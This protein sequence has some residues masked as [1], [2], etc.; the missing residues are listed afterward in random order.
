[1]K[2]AYFSVGYQSRP[3]LDAEINAIREVL[4][5]HHIHLFIF[6]DH[7]RFS[8]QE[9]QKMMQQAFRE[10]ADAD[11]L[12]AEISEKA[13]GVGIEI[14]YAVA[15]Q[16]P[17]ICLRNAGAEHSTTASGSATHSLIYAN[18][19]AIAAVLEPVLKGQ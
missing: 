18:A 1:M 14:G 9:E 13:M 15:L 5:K 6:V 10:I 2:K 17:V 11:L 16:K 4:D 7:Y 3:L 12:I 19:G 8:P